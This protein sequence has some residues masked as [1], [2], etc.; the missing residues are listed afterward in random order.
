MDYLWSDVS[1]NIGVLLILLSY[2]LLQLEKLKNTQRVYS[3]LN[4]I[5]AIS[6]LASLAITFTFTFTYC[7]LS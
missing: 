7:R 1:G 6:I 3:A 2:A 4:A 5:D